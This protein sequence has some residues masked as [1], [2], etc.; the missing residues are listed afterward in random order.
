MADI[1]RSYS[2]PGNLAELE[3]A[4]RRYM[5]LL[6]QAGHTTVRSKANLLIQA[7]GIQELLDNYIQEHPVLAKA[8][9]SHELP[10][11]RAALEEWKA[12]YHLNNTQV[13]EQLRIS[14]VT[15]WRYLSSEQ[16]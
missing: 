3:R 2:W 4:V 5:A 7:I 1:L 14:R 9:A 10:A 6:E 16:A 8:P 11:F 13:A 12:L 15:L